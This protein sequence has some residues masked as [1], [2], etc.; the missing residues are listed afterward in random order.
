MLEVSRLAAIRFAKSIPAAPPKSKIRSGHSCA[1]WPFRWACSLEIIFRHFHRV[2]HM[3][4]N[5]G[6]LM[7]PC[8]TKNI[9]S[10]RSFHGKA[11]TSFLASSLIYR[12]RVRVMPRDYSQGEANGY[13][14]AAARSDR[15]HRAPIRS[16]ARS[17]SEFR[18]LYHSR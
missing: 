2:G 15:R 12:R 5:G 11:A 17:A 10:F 7:N 8:S 18:D 6:G 9:T 14:R 4:E 16:A 1:F 13:D 3:P